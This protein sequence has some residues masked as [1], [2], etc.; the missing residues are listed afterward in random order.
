MQQSESGVFEHPTKSPFSLEKYDSR[1]EREYMEELELYSDISKWTK[2]HNIRIPYV[3]D[4]G[5]KKYFEPDFLI[6]KVD[7]TK[8]IHEVK[9]GHLMNRETELK[10]NAAKRF[11]EARKMTFRL[12][13]KSR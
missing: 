8:E 2:N 6:E 13:T 9:G 11:C 5:Y 3:D 12:I 10:M 4:A 7:G 1:W